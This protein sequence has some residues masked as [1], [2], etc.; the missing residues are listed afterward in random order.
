MASYDIIGDVHGHADK[1]RGLLTRLGYRDTGGAW[2][3]D[4]RKAIF[5][6]DFV[7]R[8]PKQVETVNIARRMVDT[9]SAL[10]VMGNHE[11]NAISWFTPDPEA[12]GEYLRPH[13]SPEDKNR[14]QHAEFLA[15]VENKP[16]LHRELI[17]WFLTLPLWLDLPELRV[18]HACWHAGHLASLAPK[19]APGTRLTPELLE[20]GARPRNPEFEAL[21][22]LTKGV[23]VALPEGI[24]FF[25][26]DKNARTDVRLK[27]WDASAT[28]YQ[29]GAHAAREVLDRLPDTALPPGSC[30]GY[31]DPKPLFIGHYWLI[32]TP[33]LLAPNVAC[34]DYSAGKGGPLVAYRYSGEPDLQQENFVASR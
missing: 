4:E 29:N 9:G 26:A 32:G 1:L 8:G 12:P 11:F 23:E 22:C 7:D 24:R 33:T 30:F 25:D 21:E 16:G 2:R 5:L 17:E 14:R 20:Q 6:G 34:V 18:V 28:T 13:A 3:H 10:A 15:E 27:W 31:G 19:L